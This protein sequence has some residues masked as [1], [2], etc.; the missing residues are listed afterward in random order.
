MLSLKKLM[1][2]VKHIN[3]QISK[4]TVPLELEMGHLFSI[5]HIPSPQAVAPLTLRSSW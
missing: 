2:M 5:M 3:A 1:R 4:P